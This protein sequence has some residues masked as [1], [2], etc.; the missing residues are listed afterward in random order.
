MCRAEGILFLI[1]LRA[2]S[3]V[4]KVREVIPRS[5]HEVLREELLPFLHDRIARQRRIDLHTA[6]GTQARPSLPDMHTR[7]STLAKGA[8]TPAGPAPLRGVPPGDVHVWLPARTDRARRDRQ[9]ERKLKP[10]ARQAVAEK[11]A[12]AAAQLTNALAN[13]KV[14]VFAV[15]LAPPMLARFAAVA[16]APD[17]AF[18]MQTADVAHEEREY[19]RLLR[20]QIGH[21]LRTNEGPSTPGR[22]VLYS[23]RD[24]RLMLTEAA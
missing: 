2:H 11:A 6:G 3:P 21:V 8:P 20:T 19:L 23:I 22:V 9:G 18:R 5:E 17:D 12:A 4:L 7:A 16:A 24:G 14:P 13:A 15:D 1:L 10:A